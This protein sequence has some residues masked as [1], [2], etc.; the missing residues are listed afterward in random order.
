SGAGTWFPIVMKNGE[1][2]LLKTDEDKAAMVPQLEIVHQG[3]N[4]IWE[5]KVAL[6]VTNSFIANKRI[7]AQIMRD[8][9]LTS[10]FRASEVRAISHAGSG[11]G[12]DVAALFGQMFDMLDAWVDKGTPPPP[13]RSDWKELGDADR[14]GVIENP[15]LSLPEIAC[16][17]GVYY[18]VTMESGSIL[19]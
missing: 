4:N 12:L 15:G 11:P 18:P 9:G 16:P 13:T 7:N 14:D 1:D 19:F 2:V 6:G 17:L 10:K 3:Y 5:T 8:K